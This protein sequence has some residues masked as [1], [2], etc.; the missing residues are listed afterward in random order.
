MKITLEN[1]QTV[2]LSKESYENLLNA[3]RET[4]QDTRWKPKEGEEYWYI[5]ASCGDA[6]ITKW[7]NN[8]GDNYRYN[9]GNCSPTRGKAIMHKKRMLAVKY[10][11]LPKEGEEYVYISC[12]G[13]I[14]TS[15]WE[16][17]FIDIQR[18]SVGNVHR[19]TEDAEKWWKEYKE[20]FMDLIK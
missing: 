8:I 6:Y 4:K 12:D 11:Y 3:V 1:G 19:T 7:R 10:R 2:E 18:Y 9:T 14:D 20:A 17:D 13:I 15:I 5:E 16:G